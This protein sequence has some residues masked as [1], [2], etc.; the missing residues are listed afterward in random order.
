MK[1]KTMTLKEIQGVNLEIMKDIHSFCVEHDIK[2]T[3]AYGTLIGAIRHKG[4]IPWDDDIDI[5]MSRPEYERFT[6]T[7][8]SKSGFMLKPG[9]D[10]DNYVNYTRVYDTKRT[11]VI[12][13]AFPCEKEIG[14]W[15]DIFPIDN[16]S[17]DNN[18]RN[19]HFQ[20]IRKLTQPLMEWRILKYRFKYESRRSYITAMIRL[21]AGMFKYKPIKWHKEIDKLLREYS[22]GSTGFVSSLVCIEANKNNK[23]EVFPISDFQEYELAKFEDA[24]FYISKNYDHI[25]KTIFGDYMSIPPKDKQVSHILKK[26]RFY[27]I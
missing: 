15:I 14:V 23:Q 6:K 7:Y 4:F 27:W 20:K 2:Y 13:N 18:E 3:L 5:M 24:E 25:L 9:T 17:E 11:L 1:M 22:Y 26:W 12:P 10:D 21:L 8:Q 16:V 19:S